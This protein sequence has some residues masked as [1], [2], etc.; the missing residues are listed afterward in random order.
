M[1]SLG[2]EPVICPYKQRLSG[3]CIKQLERFKGDNL[4]NWINTRV[5]T[6][7]NLC[8][9]RGHLSIHLFIYIRV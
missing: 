7:I 1:P 5:Y 9:V 6:R 2:R 8:I 4:I 3:F